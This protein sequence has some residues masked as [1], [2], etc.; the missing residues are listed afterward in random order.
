MQ[1]SFSGMVDTL[2]TKVLEDL[3]KT[4]AWYDNDW[5]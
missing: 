2:E 4:L 5:G 3:I 1:S